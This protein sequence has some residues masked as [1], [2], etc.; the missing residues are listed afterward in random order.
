[1]GAAARLPRC[2]KGGVDET[3]VGI[4]AR[5]QLCDTWGACRHMYCVCTVLCPNEKV[6]TLKP[7]TS[8]WRIR[9]K[10]SALQKSATMRR[11]LKGSHPDVCIS[12]NDVSI[13]MSDLLY[14]TVRSKTFT[15]WMQNRQMGHTCWRWPSP[16]SLWRALVSKL[17]FMACFAN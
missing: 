15:I 8:Y 9:F 13:Q 3:P 7:P 14:M 2:G 6:S 10:R 11:K 16:V 17:P 5:R 1:L 12:S 4:G